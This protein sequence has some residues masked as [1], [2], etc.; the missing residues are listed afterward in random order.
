MGFENTLPKKETLDS[1][2][3]AS[4][5]LVTNVQASPSCC[6]SYYSPS[7]IGGIPKTSREEEDIV[8]CR[9]T[10]AGLPY[11]DMSTFQPQNPMQLQLYEDVVDIHR[12]NNVLY[13]RTTY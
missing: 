4:G 8:L 11:H 13:L 2:F 10:L 9:N 3:A 6:P 5:K 7:G 1:T 12:K